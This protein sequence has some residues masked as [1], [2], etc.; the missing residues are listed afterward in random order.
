MSVWDDIEQTLSQVTYSDADVLGAEAIT[1]APFIGGKPQAAIAL[2]VVIDRAEPIVVAA[3]GREIRVRQLSF[4]LPN[5]QAS[6]GGSPSCN[7]GDLVTAPWKV[8][9]APQK[10]RVTA[11]P[12]SDAGGWQVVAEASAN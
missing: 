9:D 4:F 3:E 6:Q 5:S 1:Y 7:R 10:F 12:Q 2:S 11:I 8:G